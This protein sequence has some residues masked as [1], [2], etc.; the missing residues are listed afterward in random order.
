MT[1][2]LSP[3]MSR[4]LIAKHQNFFPEITKQLPLLIWSTEVLLESEITV[5]RLQVASQKDE[6]S[7]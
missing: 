1:V 3:D 5:V 2:V 6:L 7:C 4:K